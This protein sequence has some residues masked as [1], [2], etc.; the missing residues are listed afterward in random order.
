MPSNKANGRAG[1]ETVCVFVGMG[2]G[3]HLEHKIHNALI[4]H[5]P[6]QPSQGGVWCR[7]QPGSIK[8]PAFSCPNG[9]LN[10]YCFQNQRPYKSS[11]LEVCTTKLKRQI[12]PQYKQYFPSWLLH[13]LI[14][15]FIQQIIYWAWLWGIQRMHLYSRWI[16]SYRGMMP[17]VSLLGDTGVKW[18]S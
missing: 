13:V 6:H 2:V 8:T 4:W 17:G 7:L 10:V 1:C 16:K 3:G 11:A 18:N 15:S 5:C 12:S 9:C 14:Y